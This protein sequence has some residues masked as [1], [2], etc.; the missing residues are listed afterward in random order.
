MRNVR[1]IFVHCSDSP[2]GSAHVID[3]WHRARGWDGIGYHYVI[4]ET[5]EVQ[6]GRPHYWAGAHVRG[7]N[8]C[9]LGICL[10]GRGEEDFNHAQFKALV[11]LLR[12]L[13]EQYPEAV[14]LGHRDLDATKTCPGFD[15][16]DLVDEMLGLS[17]ARW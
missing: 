12:S 5:G 6:A 9:S 16:R 17:P 8:E 2:Y 3:G 11:A 4:I 15:V 1:E 14:I 10:I 13:H 7:H